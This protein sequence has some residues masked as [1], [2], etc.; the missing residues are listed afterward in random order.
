MRRS[1]V[2]QKYSVLVDA[3]YADFSAQHIK[4]EVKFEDGR[5]G[6]IEADVAIRDAKIYP[7]LLGAAVRNEQVAG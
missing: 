5:R 4:T 2:L 6:S 1:F 3:L 7:L